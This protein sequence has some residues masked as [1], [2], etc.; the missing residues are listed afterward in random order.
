MLPGASDSEPSGD[1]L[2]P[3]MRNFTP[4]TCSAAA[5]FS[6]QA[7]MDDKRTQQGSTSCSRYLSNSWDPSRRQRGAG[8]SAVVQWEQRRE[9]ASR[10]VAGTKGGGFRH[11]VA[12]SVF[13]PRP[14]KSVNTHFTEKGKKHTPSALVRNYSVTTGWLHALEMSRSMFLSQQ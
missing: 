3:P 9:E 7:E 8:D 6:Q 1:G 11:V 14:Q 2:K 12:S 4:L 13:Q 5:Q 10:A